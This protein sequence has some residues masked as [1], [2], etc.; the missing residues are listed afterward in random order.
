VQTFGVF[1]TLCTSVHVPDHL[2]YLITKEVFENF[3]YFKSQHPAYSGLT[4]KSMLQGLSAPLHP[5]AIKYFREA[6]LIQ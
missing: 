3:D 4:K 5:G 2:V 6:G 1:A